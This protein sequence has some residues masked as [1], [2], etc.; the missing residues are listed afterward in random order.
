MYS[1]L[2]VK[3]S[4]RRGAASIEF[5]MFMP[6]LIGFA[7]LTMYVIRIL[8]ARQISTIQAEVLA[9][10]QEIIIAKTKRLGQTQS[11][12]G[13]DSPDLKRLIRAFQPKL[14]VKAGLVVGKGIE[15]TGA[16]IAAA[17]VPDA[18]S[19]EN[20]I[21][22]LSHAWE[23]EVLPFPTKKSQQ[24]P[25]TFPATIRGIAPNIDLNEFTKLASFGMN[26]MS[27]R[28]T[29]GLVSRLVDRAKSQINRELPEIQNK[30][31]LLGRKLLDL[32]NSP[33]PNGN[34]ISKTQKELQELK[35]IYL[36]LKN[37]QG[38]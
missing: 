28:S 27:N 9:K 16:S 19:A 35:E 10:E 38:L 15:E 32:Q 31:Q 4:S 14:D 20:S 30:I 13:T 22:F 7:A 37:A 29:P 12:E 6:V 21:G 33:V 5:L 34:E 1:H 17:G 23:K 24:P 36:D 18:G 2:P 8:N 3:H 11:W 25:L 26:G